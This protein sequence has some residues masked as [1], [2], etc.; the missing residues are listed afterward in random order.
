MKSVFIGVGTAIIWNFASLI[1]VGSLVNFNFEFFSSSVPT[2]FVG[3]IPFKYFS[4]LFLF[5]SNPIVSNFFANSIAR[6]IPTYP[7][8]IM[9]SF[10]FFDFNNSYKSILR[11]PFIFKL[12]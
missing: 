4:I 6:T 9:E 7:S 12:V 3:S 8:P 1:K 5:I 11:P 2:S 10:S